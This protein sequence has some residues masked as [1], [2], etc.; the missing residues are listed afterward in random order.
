MASAYY[1]YSTLL[2]AK[3]A[4]ALGYEADA[5][6]YLDR[7]ERI[8]SAFQQEYFTPTGRCA[9]PTQTALALA[10]HFDLV[11]QEH[12]AR[13]LAMMK[14]RLDAQKIH[15]DTGFVGTPVLL[16]TLSRH[17][18]HDYAVTLLLNEDYP[19]WLY[20]VS[21]GATTIWERWISV[22]PD[23]LVSDTG[24]NSMNH[25]AYGSVVEWI[26]RSLAGLNP[27][28]DGPGFRRAVIAPMPE[29]RFDHI[30]C[31]YQSA[32]GLYESSWRREGDKIRYRIRIP[33]DCEAEVRLPGMDSRVLGCGEYEFTV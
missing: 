19:S 11:P 25:Y 2:T 6:L 12:R 26:Y 7:A 33:F 21:M 29:A 1:Y 32:S 30:A 24:M 3:A 27:S 8:R 31:T 9:I 5:A 10:L 15:L 13:V 28:A 16:P 23:G 17:G 14:N 18:L 4:G 20:E 22:M